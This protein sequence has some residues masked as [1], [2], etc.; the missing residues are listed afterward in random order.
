MTKLSFHKRGTGPALILIHAF[1][2]SSAMWDEL[3]AS[4]SDL[5]ISIATI[6]LPGFGRSPNAE[7]TMESICEDLYTAI[8]DEGVDRPV[9]CGLSMGGYIALS[10]CKQ[11]PLTVAG[12]ILADTKAAAD[13][14]EVKQD[15]EKFAQDALKRGAIAG[16]ERNL[17]KMTSDATKANAPDVAKQIETWMREA[18]PQAI[19]N[20]LRAMAGRPDTMELLPTIAVPVLLIVGAD[21]PV[22]TP[23]EMEK[24]AAVLPTATLVMISDASHMSVTE[25]PGEFA[26]AVRNYL[27]SL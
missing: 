4:L 2:F 8:T 11:Y 13:S 16:I 25:K 26:G 18:D 10:Y 15:R 24:M 5:D 21:D 6:D 12:L 14:E 19:A 7:W 20:A 1:P 3:I 27:V 17:A 9:L 23:L 22:T